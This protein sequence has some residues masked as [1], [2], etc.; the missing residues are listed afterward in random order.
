[1][2]V[3]YGERPEPH[4]DGSYTPKQAAELL[5]PSLA[6]SRTGS[7]ILFCETRSLTNTFPLPPPFDPHNSDPWEIFSFSPN[8]HFFVTRASPGLHL[9]K[10]TNGFPQ[11]ARMISPDSDFLGSP[12][13]SPNG[14][15]LAL[16]RGS[17]EVTI[18]AG[19]TWQQIK[20]LKQS[21]SDVVAYEFWPGAGKLLAV[22]YTDGRT[23]F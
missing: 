7:N 6:P 9:W 12:T 13:F 19:R 10:I 18:W 15:L 11:Y 8:G 14:E 3:D 22:A 17:K 4:C 1:L 5:P 21:A 23:H 20:A 16:G 2:K